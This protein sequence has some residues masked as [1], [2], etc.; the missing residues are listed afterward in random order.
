MNI[1]IALIY[2]LLSFTLTILCYKKYGKCGLYIWICISVIICNI[3]TVKLSEMFGL[4]VSLGNISYGS[5][6]LSTDIISEKYGFEAAKIATKLSF[7]VMI[8]FTIM[9]QLFL[10]YKPSSIDVTQTS[11]IN[12]FNYMPRITIGSLTAY[13][14]SQICDAK[15]YSILK[16]KTNKIWIKN[17][18]STFIS[19]IIDTI[20]FS[21]IAFYNT[22]SNIDLIKLM[23]TMMLFKILIAVLDTPF[24]ILITKMKN[25]KELE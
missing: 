3:Q 25:I 19:Q 22:M 17:N 6:F 1:I 11:L 2:L 23:I 20:I 18:I 24:M 12:I 16:Q 4:V 14:I 21:S 15:I 13:Y 10:Y 8:I 5:I 9:M 7:I